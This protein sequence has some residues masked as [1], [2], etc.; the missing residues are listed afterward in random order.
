MI[1]NDIIRELEEYK[2]EMLEK[3]EYQ[4][5]QAAVVQVVPEKEKADVQDKIKELDGIKLVLKKQLIDII[6]DSNKIQNGLQ[7][8]LQGAQMLIETVRNEYEEFIQVVKLE[9]ESYK[10]NHIQEYESLKNS[11]ESTKLKFLEEKKRMAQEYQTILVSMQ[12]HF[13]DYRKTSEFLFNAELIKLADELTTQATKYEAEILYIVQAKDKFYSDL[14]VSKDAKIMS[15]IEGSDLQSLM[16]KNELDLE[17][18][19]KEHTKEIER[20]KT[21]QEIE[22]KNIISLLQRQNV[23]LETKCDKIQSHLK[24]MEGRMK[25]LLTTID[26]KNKVITER[27]EFILNTE[28]ESKVID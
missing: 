10:N 12:N 24:I 26:Q 23:N 16:Q 18:L 28:I 14:M 4:L 19:R 1:L 15:L 2:E 22:S 11:F 6:Q 21:D 8:Q 13:E 7:N 27:D 3:E 17:N 9:Y 20:V 25:E 5:K